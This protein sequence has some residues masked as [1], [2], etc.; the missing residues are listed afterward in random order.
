MLS[1][2]SS[3]ASAFI[4]AGVDI[5]LSW[6]PTPTHSTDPNHHRQ[7]DPRSD[8]VGFWSKSEE[9]PDLEDVGLPMEQANHRAAFEYTSRNALVRAQKTWV[10]HRHKDTSNH[11]Q[12]QILL[13]EPP[14]VR[15]GGD[16]SS[17]LKKHA[18]LEL[19]LVSLCFYVPMASDL[20]YNSRRSSWW[21]SLGMSIVRCRTIVKRVTHKASYFIFSSRCILALSL[22][23]VGDYSFRKMVGTLCPCDV[24][25]WFV[26][27]SII[28]AILHG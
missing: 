13:I 2:F 25:V 12:K 18:G 7:L 8:D 15:A 1:P 10:G 4:A 11:D 21:L 16:L 9:N 5:Y 27:S 20:L 24:F 26:S 28:N 22:Q 6:G 14:P 3:E 23:P 19:A 17:Q